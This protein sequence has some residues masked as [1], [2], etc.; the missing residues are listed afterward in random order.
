M[1]NILWKELYCTMLVPGTLDKKSL[2]LQALEVD[3]L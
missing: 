1:K 3:A 2:K